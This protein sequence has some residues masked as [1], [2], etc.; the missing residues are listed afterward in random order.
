MPLAWT[1]PASI[2]A[3]SAASVVPDRSGS[4][5]K[6]GGSPTGAQP[7][8]APAGRRFVEAFPGPFEDHF[9]PEKYNQLQLR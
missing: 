2:A 7:G 3:C 8:E 9:R 5:K 1:T 6:P 4:A